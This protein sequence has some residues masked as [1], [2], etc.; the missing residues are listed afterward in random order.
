MSTRIGRGWRIASGRVFGEG[1]LLVYLHGLG[2]AGSRDWA[3]VATSPQLAGGASMWVDLLGFGQSDRPS[4]FSYDLTA[5]ADLLVELLEGESGPLV[6]IGHSMGGTLAVILAERLQVNPPLAVLV[7][8][9]NLEPDPTSMSARAAAKDPEQFFA[10]WPRWVETFPS[11][12]YREN[13]RLADPVA[14]HR[15][16]VSL[17][18]HSEGMLKRFL[19]LPVA[20]GY[21]MGG[22]SSESTH[23]VAG[24]VRAAGIGVEVVPASGHGFSEDDPHGFG[25]AIN[26]LLPPS[27]PGRES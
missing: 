19:R 13:I 15:S 8:E 20:K 27:A 2:C 6:L 1:P 9:P 21:I 7:A 18:R 4:D 5:Q 14:F 11:A 12:H 24:H 25:A 22:Q 26:R 17:V 16:S 3:P 23:R 10:A